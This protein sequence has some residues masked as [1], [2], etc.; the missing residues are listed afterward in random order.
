MRSLRDKVR[1]T[2]PRGGRR[3]ARDGDC[4]HR[5]VGGRVGW[6]GQQMRTADKRRNKSQAEGAVPSGKRLEPK[7]RWP[8]TE[9]E[10][11][12]AADIAATGGE[13]GP[14]PSGRVCG[15]C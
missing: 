14:K 11:C 7:G 8:G 3:T 10:I 1:L 13:A 6:H 15:T 5:A 12:P 9:I 4:Q 2:P